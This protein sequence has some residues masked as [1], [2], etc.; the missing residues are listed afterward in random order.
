MAVEEAVEVETLQD[1]TVGQQV[2][3]EMEEVIFGLQQHVK[4]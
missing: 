2:M 3:V 4:L 1:L